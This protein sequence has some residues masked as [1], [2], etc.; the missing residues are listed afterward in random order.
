MD[1]K[2]VYR[3]LVWTNREKEREFAAIRS[4]LQQFMIPSTIHFD[5]I[6]KPLHSLLS[7]PFPPLN[8]SSLSLHSLPSLPFPPLPPLF[9]AILRGLLCP[10][11]QAESCIL[12]SN[13]T[14]AQ[15]SNRS[16]DER[17]RAR[18]ST[19][20]RTRA[21]VNPLTRPSP[22]ALPHDPYDHPHDQ[23]PLQRILIPQRHQKNASILRGG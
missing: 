1:G 16:P 4:S 12:T 2:S 19:L 9:Q 17:T 3:R 14:T 6:W 22:P 15:S 5:M 23:C 7:P 8:A 21:R 20:I 10:T 18:P 13:Q 11:F